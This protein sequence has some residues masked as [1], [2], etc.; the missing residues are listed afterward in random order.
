MQEER[1][2]LDVLE[3]IAELIASKREALLVLKNLQLWELF[4][5]FL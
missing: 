5:Y 2:F 1:D 4:G 3:G